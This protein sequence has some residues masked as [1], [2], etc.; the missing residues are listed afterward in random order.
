VVDSWQQRLRLS[1]LAHLEM[2]YVAVGGGQGR[3]AQQ[4][5]QGH[6]VALEAQR[7]DGEGV[8]QAV[9]TDLLSHEFG[10]GTIRAST[11]SAELAG[12]CIASSRGV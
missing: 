12:S 3:I 4:L 5:L 1:Q 2:I 11:I 9:A 6:Q 7:V 10:R 8:A